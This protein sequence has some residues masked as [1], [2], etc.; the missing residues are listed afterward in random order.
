MLYIFEEAKERDIR[1]PCSTFL[2]GARDA[3]VRVQKKPQKQDIA[4]GCVS[5]LRVM[6]V[7]EDRERFQGSTPFEI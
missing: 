7:F 3:E 4:K 6:S 1:C 2:Y 5:F